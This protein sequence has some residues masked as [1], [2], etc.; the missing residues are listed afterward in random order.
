[1]KNF[2]QF[3]NKLNEIAAS[4]PITAQP[5]PGQRSPVPT[6]TQQPKSDLLLNTKEDALKLLQ[7]LKGTQLNLYGV[8]E[9]KKPNGCSAIATVADIKI[10]YNPAP[11]KPEYANYHDIS[12]KISFTIS[13]I[14]LG[15]D[16]NANT[17]FK[18]ILEEIKDTP[19]TARGGGQWKYTII[20]DAASSHL[21]SYHIG[22]T[23]NST[24]FQKLEEILLQTTQHIPWY[25]KETPNKDLFALGAGPNQ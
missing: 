1:M 18:S 7:P 16:Q 6:P 2:D 15:Q 9:D 23:K 5:I 22:A 8:T 24:F 3:L 4:Q 13:N 19:V 11:Y 10:D 20:M 25:A 17:E 14:V 12:F 21:S